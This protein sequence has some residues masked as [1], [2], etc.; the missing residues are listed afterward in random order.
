MVLLLI[1]A[2]FGAGGAG[3]AAARF[4]QAAACATGEEHSEPHRVSEQR[5]SPLPSPRPIHRNVSRREH[6][7]HDIFPGRELFQRPPPALPFSPA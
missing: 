1:P 2:A 6:R 5:T 3:W 7:P 4:T